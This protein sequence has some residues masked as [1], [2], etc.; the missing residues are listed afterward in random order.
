MPMGPSQIVKKGVI[1]PV[2]AGKKTNKKGNTFKFKK[3]GKSF[4][5]GSP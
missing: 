4:R 2:K 3:V 1:K 5:G